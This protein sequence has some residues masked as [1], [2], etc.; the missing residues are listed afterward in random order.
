LILF[1]GE[2]GSGKSTLAGNFHQVGNPLIAD[3][4]LWLKDE[5]ER[6]SAIPTYGGLRLWE[7]SLDVLFPS[8][9]PA[10]LMAQYSRKKRVIF[11]ETKGWQSDEGI[12]VLGVFALTQASQTSSEEIIIERLSHRDAF[13]A[14]LKQT[15]QLDLK[16]YERVKSHILELGCVVPKL[17]IFRLTMPH[18]YDLLPAVRQRILDAV[19]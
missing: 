8:E 3:D 5:S 1:I 10:R 4:C 7:D 18:K 13:I 19:L 14:M 9:Q 12:Q 11:S 6:V 15:F 2:S 17:R 16:D